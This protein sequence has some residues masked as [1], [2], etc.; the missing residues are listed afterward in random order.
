MRWESHISLTQGTF[1]YCRSYTGNCRVVL[2]GL[3]QEDR[4]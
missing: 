3:V 2:T 4:G 1:L